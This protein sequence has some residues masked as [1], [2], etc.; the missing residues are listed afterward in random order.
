MSM[1]ATFITYTPSGEITSVLSCDAVIAPQIIKA[2][3]SLPFV[4]IVAPVSPEAYYAPGGVLTAR[5]ASTAHLVGD[6]LKGVPA[7]AVVVIEGQ[8]YTADG[9]DIVLEFEHP[10]IYLIKVDAFPQKT[11]EGEFIEDQA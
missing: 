4:Q 3:T 9:T 1:P 11:W 6:L 7:G 5:P 10:G 2:N 8:E